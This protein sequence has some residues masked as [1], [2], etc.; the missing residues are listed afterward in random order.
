MKDKKEW[1]K[2]FDLYF[3]GHLGTKF[4]EK[5]VKLFIRDLLAK[6]IKELRAIEKSCTDDKFNT[7]DT[8]LF[9]S[10]VLDWMAKEEK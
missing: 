6:Q 2:E 7:M 5:K 9:A 10:K 3:A 4:A 8:D 1:E